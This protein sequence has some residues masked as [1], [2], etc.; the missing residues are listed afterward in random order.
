M[1]LIKSPDA[2]RWTSQEAFEREVL[3]YLGVENV[4]V[5]RVDGSTV[6]RGAD[7]AGRKVQ[8]VYE[9]GNG[10][11]TAE[12]IELHG[13]GEQIA[14]LA[15]WVANTLVPDSPSVWLTDVTTRV[16]HVQLAPGML[17]EDVTEHWV[18]LRPTETPGRGVMVIDVGPDHE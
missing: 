1:F 3:A 16:G 9:S 11:D 2:L 7:L 14:D 18:G 15:V 6:V 4:H 17:K 5:T 8:M 13:S 12:R 10:T